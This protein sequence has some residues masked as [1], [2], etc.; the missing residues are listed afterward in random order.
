MNSVCILAG[1]VKQGKQIRSNKEKDHLLS[2]TRVR[3]PCGR[4]GSGQPGG[5]ERTCFLDIQNLVVS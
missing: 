5:I 3:T 1:A 4:S 2:Q